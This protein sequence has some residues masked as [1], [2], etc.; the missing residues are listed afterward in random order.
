[1]KINRDFL[2]KLFFILLALNVAFFGI[3]ITTRN[4][5]VI[6]RVVYITS[7]PN[8]ESERAIISFAADPELAPRFQFQYL[9]QNSP[10]YAEYREKF[11]IRV[12]SETL[13]LSPAGRL[14]FRWSRIPSKDELLQHSR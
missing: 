14:L 4:A 1:V 6:P 5:V 11:E 7:S 3:R 8:P 9:T 13:L 2:I 12:S 10:L